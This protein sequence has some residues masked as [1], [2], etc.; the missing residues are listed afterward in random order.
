[1]RKRIYSDHLRG[2]QRH[3]SVPY[4]DNLGGYV[5]A[6][7]LE[8]NGPMAVKS[9]VTT[10][11]QENGSGMDPSNQKV[12]RLDCEMGRPIDPMAKRRSRL[13]PT[14]SISPNP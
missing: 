9:K 4:L 2:Q 7:N 10:M 1:M 8:Q 12:N 14:F 11:M 6:K 3:I 5:N 13:Q